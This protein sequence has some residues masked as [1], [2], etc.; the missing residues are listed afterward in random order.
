MTTA[1]GDGTSNIMYNV[2]GPSAQRLVTCPGGYPRQVIKVET[3]LRQLRFIWAALPTVITLNN[4][5]TR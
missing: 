2:E 1:L 5:T 3:L 4:Y